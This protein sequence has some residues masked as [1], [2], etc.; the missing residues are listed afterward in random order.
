MQSQKTVGL[1]FRVTPETESRLVAA[2]EHEHRSLTN[3][4]E[5]LVEDFSV[6][7]GIADQV[8]SASATKRAQKR[9]KKSA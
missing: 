3:M 6:R 2:A 1:T 9:G 8:P 5:V 4:L 7:T